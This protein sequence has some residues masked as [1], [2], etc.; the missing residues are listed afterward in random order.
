MVVG[1]DDLSPMSRLFGE[2]ALSRSGGTPWG[3]TVVEGRGQWGMTAPTPTAWKRK[4]CE[5]TAELR[6]ARGWT[7][8]QMAD[9][10]AIPLER[11]KK[12]EQRSP[13]P[14]WLVARFALLADCEISD[15]YAI[16]KPVRKRPG[17]KKAS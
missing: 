2:Q 17:P 15:L 5:R 11:Y 14:Q 3:L 6:E 4:F 10:L 13:L 9:A 1:R 8:Q 12:Y 7:Q 16:D